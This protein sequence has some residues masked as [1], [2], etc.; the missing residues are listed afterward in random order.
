MNN[1]SSI[2]N[3][4]G[5]KMLDDK[6]SIYFSIQI[7]KH[8]WVTDYYEFYI[9]VVLKSNKKVVYLAKRYSVI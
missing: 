2:D 7:Y 1:D 4:L 5:M 3:T 6:N 8:L 9:K